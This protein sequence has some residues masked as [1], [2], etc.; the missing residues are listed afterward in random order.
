MIIEQG[1]VMSIFNRVEVYAGYSM[2]EF[3]KAA[4]AL[5]EAKVKYRW[6]THSM[7]GSNRFSPGTDI[8]YSM[9]YVITVNGKD[10]ESARYFINKAL[11]G[12]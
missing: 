9:Q 1:C 4:E 5:E 11:H 8:N 3:N 12:K 2:S 10:A 6:R 7:G